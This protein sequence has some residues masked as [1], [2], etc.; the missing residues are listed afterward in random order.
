MKKIGVL[1]YYC[2]CKQAFTH[3]KYF[4]CFYLTF[5]T[6][7]LNCIVCKVFSIKVNKRIINVDEVKQELSVE[8]IDN[9]TEINVVR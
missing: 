4:F 2:L 3:E 5:L 6:V 9:L 1:E 8:L 7:V